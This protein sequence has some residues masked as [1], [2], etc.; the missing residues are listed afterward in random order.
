MSRALESLDCP[1]EEFILLWEVLPPLSVL[2][3]GV[4]DKTAADEQV[5]RRSI[6]KVISVRTAK[7]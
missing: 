1:D 5:S 3:V 2:K 7:W 4:G 6:V